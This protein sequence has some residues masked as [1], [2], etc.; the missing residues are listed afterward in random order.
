MS[1]KNN[2]NRV[3]YSTNPNYRPDEPEADADDVSSAVQ[4]LYVSLDRKQR[5]GKVVT[6][7]EGFIGT[8][9]LADTVCREL[10]SKCGCGGSVK[11]G[12][13]LIQGDFRQ[14][15]IDLLKA[16]GYTVK[17]KGGN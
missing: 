3:V 7:V 13:I 10:K 2:S 15:V 9:E 8:D 6:L 5:G 4:K 1:K 17:T 14:K 11:D 16:K 12:V